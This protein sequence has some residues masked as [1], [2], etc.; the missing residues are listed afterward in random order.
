MS[1]IISNRAY[2]NGGHDHFEPEASLD[3]TEQ[4]KLRG[5]LEQ[6][7]YSAFAANQEIL[8]Q[9]IGEGDLAKFQRLAVAS[10]Q[11]R[12]QWVSAAIGMVAEG[13]R[14][15]PAQIAELSALRSAYEELIEVYE[16][17]RR[18]VERGYLHF[19]APK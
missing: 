1:A 11:A 18:M 7:D 6:I 13:H 10:A 14:P 17:L 8:G 16:A 2:R 9:A 4:R 5:H 3:P 12:A 15:S 19:Q